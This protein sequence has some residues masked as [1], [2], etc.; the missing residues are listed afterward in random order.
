MGLFPFARQRFGADLSVF[1]R[2]LVRSFPSFAAAF[3]FF[4][5]GDR[6]ID[7]ASLFGWKY[8]IFSYSLGF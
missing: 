1:H 8:E 4:A 5:H 3:E 2:S 7:V 6:L